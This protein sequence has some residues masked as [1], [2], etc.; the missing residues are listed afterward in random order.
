VFQTDR[1]IERGL[2][3]GF[4]FRRVDGS[5]YFFNPGSDDH[6]TVVSIGVSF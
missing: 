5:V 3:V 6:Y 1:D 2:L 4:A